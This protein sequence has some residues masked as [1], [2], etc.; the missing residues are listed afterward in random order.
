[1]EK[2]DNNDDTDNNDIVPTVHDLMS[3][4]AINQL[5]ETNLSLNGKYCKNS[6]CY[7]IIGE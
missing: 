5:I 2:N 6:G 7:L 1:M 4:T 3:H